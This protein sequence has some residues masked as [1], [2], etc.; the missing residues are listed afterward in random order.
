MGGSGM[1]LKET[2]NHIAEDWHQDHR[3]D[4]WWIEGTEKFTALLQPGAL[5]LDVGCGGGTK[6]HYLVEKGLRVVGIDFSE[7]MIEIA[8][9]EVP[10][11]DFLVCDIEEV[12]KL[13][14]QFDGIFIQAVLLHIP[15]ADVADKLGSLTKKLRDDGYVYVSVKEKR[16]GEAEEEVK[17]E[18]DYGYR[19]KRFFSY[20]T[21]EEV[22]SYMRK[23][24]LEIVY[25]DVKQSGKTNWIQVIAKKPN[26]HHEK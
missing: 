8:R 12:S 2:Y 20:Y 23:L 22:E 16:P 26:R 18:R 25:A 3:E 9:R 5:V 21:V 24:G 17:E 6:S 15:K 7:K 10:N 19:Y 13:K 4:D 1:N 11:A 14:Q